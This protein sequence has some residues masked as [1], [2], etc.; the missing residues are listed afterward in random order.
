LQQLAAERDAAQARAEGAV[1]TGRSVAH[2]L[3]SPLGTILGLTELLAEDRRLPEDVQ[4]DL[5]LLREQALRA[6]ELLGRF[7]RLARYEEMPTPAGLQ[8]DLH[9]SSEERPG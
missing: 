1:R 6:G 4:A 2:E 9:R 8:L 5:A 7:G 3:G